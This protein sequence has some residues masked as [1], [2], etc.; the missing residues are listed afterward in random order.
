[1]AKAED[2]A[3]WIVANADKQG[4][5]DFDT[6]AKAYQEAKAAESGQFD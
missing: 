3:N 2:Y 1:M 5:S 4:T 6:I